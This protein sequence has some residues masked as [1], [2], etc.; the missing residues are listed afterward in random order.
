MGQ[1]IL[2][3]IYSV[4]IGIIAGIFSSLLFK[5]FRFFTHSS[6]TET[7]VIFIIAMVT[8]FISEAFELSGMISLLTCGV[9]MGHY[10][11][12]NLSPQGKT[13][14]SVSVSIFG[15]AAEAVVFAYIG[16]C[17]FTYSPSADI[18]SA[19]E[20]SVTFI[21]WMLGIVIFGRIIAVWTAHFLF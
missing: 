21:A 2:L 9:I 3:A 7:L 6:I 14:S 10:T 5:W 13:I 11:W 16:L 12:Y 1:F 19:H 18:D 8:Y 15:A 4:S 20:W 17:V